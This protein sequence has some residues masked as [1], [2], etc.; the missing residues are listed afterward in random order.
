MP[1]VLRE[2][3]L[4]AV[5]LNGGGLAALLFLVGPDQQTSAAF[6]LGAIGL[7]A[8][9]SGYFFLYLLRKRDNRADRRGGRNKAFGRRTQFY[10]VGSFLYVSASLSFFVA[11]C[12]ALFTEWAGKN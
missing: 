2:V 1:A 11:G 7:W 3:L 5:A 4:I 8:G 6:W 10:L 12:V 9:L